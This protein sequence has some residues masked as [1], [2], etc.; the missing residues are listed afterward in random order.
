MTRLVTV[1]GYVLVVVIG[2][3]LELVAR[4]TRRLATFEEVLAAVLRR[5]PLR[6]LLQAG[7]LWIGWHVFVRVD[8]R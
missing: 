7:W 5:W 1:A 6:V 2:L 8:W 3:G 4:R